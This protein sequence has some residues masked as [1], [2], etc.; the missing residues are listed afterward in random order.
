MAPPLLFMKYRDSGACSVFRYIA[1][2][3]SQLGATFGSAHTTA[4]AREKGTNRVIQAAS[5]VYAVAGDGLYIFDSGAG[6]WATAG[7]G[8]AF[9]TPSLADQHSGAYLVYIDGT[10]YLT[11][12]YTNTA[13][14]HVGWRKNLV[15]GA[16]DE[17]ASSGLTRAV[18][19]MSSILYRNNLYTIHSE[20]ND[21]RTTIWDPAA[22]S[23]SQVDG[24]GLDDATHLQHDL[25]VFQDRL[26]SCAFEGTSGAVQLYEFLGGTWT[27]AFENPG[28]DDDASTA[29]HDEDRWALFTDGTNMYLLYLS[30]NGGGSGN[31]WKCFQFDSAL[32]RTDITAA[33]LP[34]S[35]RSTGDGGSFAGSVLTERFF[36]VAD[37][38]STPGSLAIYLYHTVDGTGGTPFTAFQWNGNAS[39]ITQLDVGGDVLHSVPDLTPQGGSRIYTQDELDILIVDRAPILGGEQIDFIAYGDTGPTDKM[40][41]FRRNG[42]MH[43]P[44]TIATLTGTPSKVSG[45]SSAPISRNV[46]T[47]ENVEADG[48]TIWRTTWDISTDG[49]SPGDRAQLMPRV[50]V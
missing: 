44:T 22:Q 20:S 31:G 10:P 14:D 11:G 35:F 8:L 3:L 12:W 47:L 34:A 23:F 13:Q 43:P 21:P 39:V 33:V 45:P 9:T 41:E 2:T 40:V 18:N 25:C 50:F 4:T 46:N 5:D 28:P 38:D 1:A 16:F 27:L 7:G 32:V 48:A 36:S 6:T 42:L 29:G 30:T 37:V 49:F 26:F 24:T 15:T 19:H 17:T